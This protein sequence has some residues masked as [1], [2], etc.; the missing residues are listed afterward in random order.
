[1]EGLISIL[2]GLPLQKG[3]LTKCS[4]YTGLIIL[5]TMSKESLKKSLV[6]G[7]YFPLNLNAFFFIDKLN[8]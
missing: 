5:L 3:F 4:K 7:K 6:L 1:M 8:S 2:S